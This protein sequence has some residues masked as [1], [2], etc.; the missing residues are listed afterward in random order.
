M[1]Y[2]DVNHSR[3]AIGDAQ[4]LG[5]VTAAGGQS[6]EVHGA[7]D[8]AALLEVQTDWVVASAALVVLAVVRLVGGSGGAASRLSNEGSDGGC[9]E[10]HCY[11]A[12]IQ[13]GTVTATAAAES[14]T[15]CTDTGRRDPVEKPQSTRRTPLYADA[16]RRMCDGGVA[17]YSGDR[18]EVRGACCSEAV[19]AVQSCSGCGGYCRMN[20]QCRCA[21]LHNPTR[22]LRRCSP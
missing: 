19:V 17:G 2:A 15:E 6:F 13:A 1:F 11:G 18:C 10:G 14:L 20:C 8:L 16:L 21:I 5:T 3:M 22:R 12:G 4:A 7:V 9:T